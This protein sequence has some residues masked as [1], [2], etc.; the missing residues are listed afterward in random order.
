M[1]SGWTNEDATILQKF[2]NSDTGRKFKQGFKE[3]EPDLEAATI[4]GRAMQAAEFSQWRKIKNFA[5]NALQIQPEEKHEDNGIPVEELDV[6][7][8]A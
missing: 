8:D 3:T 5:K 7:P 1:I 6:R 2:L 4:D